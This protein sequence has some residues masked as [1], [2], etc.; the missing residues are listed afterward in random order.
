MIKF[1]ALHCWRHADD[2]QNSRSINWQLRVIDVDVLKSTVR[3]VILSTE[4]VEN[5][6]KIINFSASRTNSVEI[7]DKFS[8]SFGISL[9]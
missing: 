7:C 6:E 1:T 5:L 4:I 3:R 2:E 9:V 8:L